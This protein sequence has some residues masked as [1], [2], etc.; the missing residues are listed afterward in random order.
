MHLKAV[1]AILIALSQQCEKVG[2]V[3]KTLSS[4]KNY[5]KQY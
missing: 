1:K 5:R 3:K 2:Q 4:V